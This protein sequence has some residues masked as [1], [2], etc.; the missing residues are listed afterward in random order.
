MANAYPTLAT[1]ATLDAGIGYPVVDEVVAEYKELDIFP[2]DTM[3]GVTMELSVLTTL[4]TAGFRPV[5]QVVDRKVATFE[6]KQFTT[7]VLEQQIG[8]DPMV[9]KGSKDPARVLENLTKPHMRAV[10]SM[11]AKQIWYGSGPK[12]LALGGDS[13]GFRQCWCGDRNA[14]PRHVSAAWRASPRVRRCA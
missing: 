7:E 2:S 9:I 6:T 3:E 1:V 12:G 4:P 11:I 5:N 8:A 13:Y 10:M 14:G